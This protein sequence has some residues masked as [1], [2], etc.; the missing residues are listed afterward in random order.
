M[1]ESD[2]KPDIN[3]LDNT[4]NAQQLLQQKQAELAQLDKTQ[5]AV[6]WAHCNLDIADALLALEQKEE[7][8]QAAKESFDI[9]LQHENWQEAVE[10]CNVMY[11]TEQAGAINALGQGVWLAITYPIE[12][13]TTV[14]MLHNIVEDTPKDADG[15]AV[16]A[17]TAHYIA[18]LRT[19][20]DKQESLGFLTTHIL[21]QVAKH[22]SS[23]ENQEAFDMWIARLQ[24]DKPEELLPRMAKIIDVMVEDNWW[25][26]RDELRSK[27]PDN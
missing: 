19:S 18:N 22:H 20:G 2:I 24:L 4:E 26:D 9:F 12:A 25:F 21:G 13:E 15:A 11:Q 10:A 14:T 1:S 5:Q 8:W 17:A 6:Q 23:V 3:M 16:A 27:L 7:A